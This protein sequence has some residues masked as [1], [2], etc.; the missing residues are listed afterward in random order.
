MDDKTT[1]QVDAIY[2]DFQK[3]FDK[4]SHPKLMTKLSAL[5]VEGCFHRWIGSF[6]SNRTQQ[7][8]VSG[9]FSDAEIV[10]SG[11]PQGTVLAPVLFIAFIHDINETCKFSKIKLFADDVTLFKE[12]SVTNP[13]LDKLNLQSD[14]DSIAEFA[15]K[16]GSFP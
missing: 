5:G 3:A 10:S 6:L 8:E 9:I 2:L 11:V 7:V 15:K 13:T 4:V 14:L 12:I 16:N 1:K